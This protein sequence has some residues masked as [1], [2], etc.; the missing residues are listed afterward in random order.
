MQMA[1]E[2][3]HSLVVLFGLLRVDS[4]S[5]ISDVD[6]LRRFRNLLIR[7]SLQEEFFKQVVVMLKR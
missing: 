2:A 1:V 3:I 4:S 7:H 5:Q 6:M